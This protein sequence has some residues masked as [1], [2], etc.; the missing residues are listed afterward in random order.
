MVNRANLEVS[1]ERKSD[2][3]LKQRFE[4]IKREITEVWWVDKSDD[5]IEIV[6][7]ALNWQFAE[8]LLQEKNRAA[9]DRLKQDV[10]KMRNDWNLG[11]KAW[12]Q[13]EKLYDFLNDI[14]EDK[15][16][17]K[18]YDEFMD[19]VKNKPK[20]LSRMNSWEIRRLNLYLW[21]HKD[22][23][24]EAYKSMKALPENWA[25]SSQDTMFFDSVWESLKSS[26]AGDSDFIALDYP[27]V[28]KLQ[29]T[30]ESLAALAGENWDGKS[31]TISV[32]EVENSIVDVEKVN[33]MVRSK[34]EERIM[35]N[36]EKVKAITIDVDLS[37]FTKE[38][39]ELKY[40]WNVFTVET[41]LD[42]F[43]DKI[44]EAACKDTEFVDEEERKD[45]INEYKEDIFNTLISL[46]DNDQNETPEGEEENDDENEAPVERTW[47]YEEWI[48]NF[49]IKMPALKDRIKQ[50]EF[51]DGNEGW[52]KI[53]FNIDK[54]KEY[55]EK[56]CKGKSWKDLEH[57]NAVD[58]ATWT[59]SV[60]ILLNHL[61]QRDDKS[62]Y[63]V[64]YI[65]GIRGDKTVSWVKAFQ[66]DNGLNFRNGQPDGLPGSVTIDKLLA[67]LWWESV[68]NT[69]EW[70]SDEGDPV[71][72]EDS[73]DNWGTG[74][75]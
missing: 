59:I 56:N 68:D 25:N 29:P 30:V 33:E 3:E 37:K 40:D 24:L 70:W 4:D 61:A 16:M 18:D 50:L 53:T 5:E 7:W 43:W 31:E 42:I 32:S 60:Q 35:S 11:A 1:M 17:Q 54:V 44:N 20:S 62:D 34:N 15:K 12:P 73:T 52:E 2:E 28:G 13:L 47:T 48:E 46:L 57:S 69:W 71:V 45:M 39:W 51:Y 27:D 58:R 49:K 9:F 19:R 64:R 67:V 36:I 63:N 55:L 14:T 74:E 10:S 21:M 66:R 41:M 6:E 23:A 22:K 72:D 8:F 26:Y 75:S 38:E 65:D